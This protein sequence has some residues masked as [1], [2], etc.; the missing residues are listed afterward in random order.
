LAVRKTKRL[1]SVEENLWCLFLQFLIKE[2]Y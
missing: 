2:I 1:S